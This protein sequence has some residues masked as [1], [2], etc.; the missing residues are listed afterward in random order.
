LEAAYQSSISEGV[1]IFIGFG[2]G[3]VD[4]KGVTV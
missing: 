3:K 2:S 4:K 1:R